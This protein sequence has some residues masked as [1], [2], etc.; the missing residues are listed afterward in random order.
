MVQLRHDFLIDFFRNLVQ[1]HLVACDEPSVLTGFNFVVLK[2]R[3]FVN[4][5]GLIAHA[6]ALVDGVVTVGGGK[7]TYVESRNSRGC[8]E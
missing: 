3:H 2:A 7:P 8:W 1:Q 6:N 4:R 5:D